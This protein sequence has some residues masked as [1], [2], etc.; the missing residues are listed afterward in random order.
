MSV[1]QRLVRFVR[2]IV[3]GLSVNFVGLVGRWRATLIANG[4]VPRLAKLSVITGLVGLVV[5][6]LQVA[7]T[8]SNVVF[9][10]PLLHLNN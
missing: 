2:W 8:Q 10:R 4:N 7:R 5:A 1:G 6:R 9:V 3:K